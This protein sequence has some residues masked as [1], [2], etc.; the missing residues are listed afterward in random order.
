MSCEK[1]LEKLKLPCLELRRFRGDLI[2]VYKIVHKHYDRPSVSNL[3]IFYQD[4]RLRGHGYEITKFLIKKRQY[5]HFFSNRISYNNKDN[6]HHIHSH[7]QTYG[8]TFPDKRQPATAA[9]RWRDRAPR[10]QED[11]GRPFANQGEATEMRN[12]TGGVMY[13]CWPQVRGPGAIQLV[14][15]IQL[16]T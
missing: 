14:A 6:E 3:F 4:R 9:D 16:H 10:S 12:N 5:Q 7:I 2:Q 8:V 15:S 13:P 11:T 1:R